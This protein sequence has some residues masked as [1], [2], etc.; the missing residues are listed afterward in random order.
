MIRTKT[1]RLSTLSDFSVMKPGEELAGGLA[2]GEDQQPEPEQPG[3]D[4]PDG[5]P[6]SGFLD[7]DVM[8]FAADEEVDRDE[9]AQTDNGQHPQGHGNVHCSSGIRTANISVVAAGGLFHPG[10]EAFHD[11]GCRRADAPGSD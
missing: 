9:G 1:K 8:G 11:A 4:D 2:A 6:D 3:E 10:L 7:G 5:G